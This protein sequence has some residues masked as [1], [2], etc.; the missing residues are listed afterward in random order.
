MLSDK[1]WSRCILNFCYY[2]VA[3][4]E[5]YTVPVRKE[6]LSECLLHYWLCGDSNFDDSVMTYN[7]RRLFCLR[8]KS[9]TLIRDLRIPD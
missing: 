6:R 2:A 5:L 8:V 1:G 9:M 3:L 4:N 7:E